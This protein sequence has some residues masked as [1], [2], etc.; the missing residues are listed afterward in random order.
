MANFNVGETVQALDELRIWTKA[1]ILNISEDHEKSCIYT[2]T[3]PGWDAS[4]NRNVNE[5]QLRK[6]VPPYEERQRSEYFMHLKKLIFNLWP[7]L[8]ILCQCS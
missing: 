8:N 1:R 7:D 5:K 6:P 3:F 2:V 4:H